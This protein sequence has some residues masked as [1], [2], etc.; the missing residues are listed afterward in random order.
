[1]V[2]PRRLRSTTAFRA[3]ISGTQ[4]SCCESKSRPTKT[5]ICDKHN[6]PYISLFVT[7]ST[8]QSRCCHASTAAWHGECA[9]IRAGRPQTFPTDLH[10]HPITRRCPYHNLYFNCNLQH[11]THNT[12]QVYLINC[13]HILF[14]EAKRCFNCLFRML[15]VCLKCFFF[16]TNI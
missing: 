7:L 12:I 16:A 3:S 1:M 8:H 15:Y 6:I 2:S 11:P 13:N 10:P 9:L 5:P 14:C 4:P